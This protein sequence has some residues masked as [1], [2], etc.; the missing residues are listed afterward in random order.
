MMMEACAFAKNAQSLNNNHV[1]KQHYCENEC[2]TCAH[3]QHL[4]LVCGLLHA[5]FCIMPQLKA[6]GKY[7]A[8]HALN[9]RISVAPP[10]HNQMFV[11]SLLNDSISTIEDL[12]F[13]LL[14]YL[15]LSMN[16]SKEDEKHFRQTFQ[17]DASYIEFW[18]IF[19]PLEKGVEVVS[20]VDLFT[21]KRKS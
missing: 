3:H 16:A 20:R 5:V 4:G 7:F 15:D 8:F 19:V 14:L 10:A 11:H 6:L 9:L 1:V 18:T 2:A 21:Q 13:I 12:S 17:A